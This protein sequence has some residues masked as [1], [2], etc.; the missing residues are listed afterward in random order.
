MAVVIK[1][2]EPEDPRVNGG[3][4]GPT[5]IFYSPQMRSEKVFDIVHVKE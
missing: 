4:S 2:M 3:N 1:N 5:F